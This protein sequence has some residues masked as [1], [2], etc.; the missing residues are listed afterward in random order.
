[1]SIYFIF[2]CTFKTEVKCE[3]LNKSAYNKHD[4][5]FWEEARTPRGN[6]FLH[7]E[8]MHNFTKVRCWDAHLPHNMIPRWSSLGPFCVFQPCP[9]KILL[10]ATC[11]LLTGF[12]TKK[13]VMSACVFICVCPVM[14]WQPDQ[15][16]SDSPW[17]CVI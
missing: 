14:D 16:E 11:I 8:H 10:G 9:H 17:P 6:V 7:G 15:S 3:C 4:C 1:M 2:T 5:R 12:T 13:L